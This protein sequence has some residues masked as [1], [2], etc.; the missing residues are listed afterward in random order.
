MWRDIGYL[1][2][3]LESA[4]ALTVFAAGRNR[5]SLEQ[6]AMLRDAML[7]RISIIGEAAGKVSAEM[8]SRIHEIPWP[9][10]ISMRNRLIH[11]YRK[12]DLDIVWDVAGT[13]AP[14]LVRIIERFLGAM[15]IRREDYIRPS[16]PP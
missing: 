4:R 7:Y 13:H 6:D 8:Q 14:E 11:E 1:V 2:D 16:P 9:Q 10:I 3:M 15:G 12:V 5:P